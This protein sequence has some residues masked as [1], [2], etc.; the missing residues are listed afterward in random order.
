MPFCYSSSHGVESAVPAD[1]QPCSYLGHHATGMP[2]GWVE[3][4]ILLGPTY[5]T[6]AVPVPCIAS[7]WGSS[8]YGARCCS[9]VTLSLACGHSVEEVTQCLKGNPFAKAYESEHFLL[10]F[11]PKHLENVP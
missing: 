4:E 10:C 11:P 8:L 7:L 6:P 5:D 9:V 3:A 2:L 1:S